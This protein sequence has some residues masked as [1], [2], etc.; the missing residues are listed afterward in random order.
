[1]KLRGSVSQTPLPG[2]PKLQN[3]D[4]SLELQVNYHLNS[5]EISTLPEDGEDFLDE[6]FP[7]FH[8]LGLR[9]T[10]LNLTP[11]N[12]Y[13]VWLLELT[14]STPA[15]SSG[16]NPE[17]EETIE[18]DTDEYEAPL[19]S[20]EGYRTNWDHVLLQNDKSQETI[21]KTWWENAVNT[22]IP[23][24]AKEQVKWAKVDDGV[25]DGWHV[26]YAET[27]PGVTGRLTGAGV[28]TVTV[29]KNSKSALTRA[30]KSDY[31]RQ[32]PPDTFE[33]SGEWLRCGSSIRKEG[34]KWVLTVKY[35]N[36]KKIEE[37]LYK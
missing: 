7:Q 37:R 18:Y 27:M 23:D 9:L 17:A 2:Y 33:Q 19:A 36:A 30:M 13:S 26:V 24:E 32:T 15:D 22:V 16:E 8:G 10:R 12:G 29:R 20:C 6:R 28:V 35:R 5:T 1:M 34:K 14:Y 25:P 11:K 21:N 31:T 3:Q 4:G